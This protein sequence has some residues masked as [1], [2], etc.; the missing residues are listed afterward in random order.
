MADLAEIFIRTKG[1]E[2]GVPEE[3]HGILGDGSTPG[4]LR[5]ARFET[6]LRLLQ[7]DPEFLWKTFNVGNNRRLWGDF[8]TEGQQ[9]S[10]LT[11]Y[12]ISR[13]NNSSSLTKIEELFDSYA[14]THDLSVEDE[15]LLRQRIVIG[16]LD[17]VGGFY[18]GAW[19]TYNEPDFAVLKFL[20]QEF[21]QSQTILDRYSEMVLKSVS[22]LLRSDKNCVE[23]LNYFIHN[24]SQGYDCLFAPIKDDYCLAERIRASLTKNSLNDA[25]KRISKLNFVVAS[26]HLNLDTEAYIEY[27]LR[28][29]AP[30]RRFLSRRQ[31]VQELLSGMGKLYYLS[32]RKRFEHNRF[33]LSFQLIEW[34]QLP[35]F[36]RALTEKDIRDEPWVLNPQ[37]PY[38]QISILENVGAANA[39]AME[40]YR[41]LN[42]SELEEYFLKREAQMAWEATGLLQE[43]GFEDARLPMQQMAVIAQNSERIFNTAR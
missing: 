35:K 27:F 24:N 14:E 34:I 32:E 20:L 5:A 31:D 17:S 22:S 1:F 16:A 23:F 9:L 38:H 30:T 12:L 10:F 6:A 41:R 39:T 33:L 13:P 7:S 37:D 19:V 4:K 26:K 18:R 2:N 25:A 21:S 43:L 36:F 8:R 29:S 11:C 3:L 40:N 42:E 28:H 15:S